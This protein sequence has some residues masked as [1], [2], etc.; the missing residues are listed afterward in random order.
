MGRMDWSI[1][2]MAGVTGRSSSRV[3]MAEIAVIAVAVA[4]AGSGGWF[5]ESVVEA[6]PSADVGRVAEG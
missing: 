2:F 4:V 1:G 3:S 6:S 5:G